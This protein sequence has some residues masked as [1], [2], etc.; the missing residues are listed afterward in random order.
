MWVVVR[1]FDRLS[2]AKETPV[3]QAVKRMDWLWQQCMVLHF[4]HA[5]TVR[6]ASFCHSARNGIRIFKGLIGMVGTDLR[7][8]LGM[9]Q[10]KLLSRSIG[11]RRTPQ[12]TTPTPNAATQV[13]SDQ[14]MPASLFFA[15]R[16]LEAAVTGSV[17]DATPDHLLPQAAT[18]LQIHCF[19]RTTALLCRQK[20]EQTINIM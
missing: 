12:V 7:T 11:I 2:V 16:T 19:K 14:I 5:E 4:T 6:A 20:E 10:M 1:T 18:S 8:W 3:L 13:R 17:D 15:S 9:K